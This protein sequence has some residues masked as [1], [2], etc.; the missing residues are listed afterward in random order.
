[1]MAAE[2]SAILSAYGLDPGDVHLTPMGSGHIH[3]TYRV[4]RSGPSLVLQRMNNHVF[5]DIPLLMNNLEIITSHIADKNRKAGKNPAEHGILLI[6]AE[7]GRSWIEDEESGFWRM[8]WFIEDQVS[9]DIAED[10]KLAYEGGKAIAH[11][12]GMLE[13][14]DP[15]RI[16]ESIPGFHDFGMRVEKFDQAVKAASAERMNEAEEEILYTRN[17]VPHVD[18]LYRSSA[19][20]NIPVRLTHNDTK[21]NNML[22]G[23]EGKVTC[24]IDL[25]TVMPGYC[26]YDF[27]DAL[28]T[29][30]SLVSEEEQDLSRVGFRTG[31]FESFA[32]G[33]L[34][35]AGFLTDD[36]ISVL[37]RA[38]HA[39]AFMQGMRFLTD[40]LE[41]DVYYKTDR[42]DHNLHRTR[43][44]FTLASELLALEEKLGGI[45]ASLAERARD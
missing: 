28:R 18:A 38:P 17:H 2:H 36:E 45:I 10:G 29:C 37:H 39:F 33:F 35:E 26:W 24:L 41:G 4:N 20:A 13:D 27:G 14:L 6:E 32:K 3:D 5:R 19:S 12:Q 8:F 34:E 23:P 22:F 9:Y 40:Y 16:G 21:F 1:M 31:I 11:F 7:G 30:A 44:Q 42:S 15:G 25:D 43:N